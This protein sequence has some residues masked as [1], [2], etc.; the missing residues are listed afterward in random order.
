MESASCVVRESGGTESSAEKS[1]T[2]G[3]RGEEKRNNKRTPSVQ[4]C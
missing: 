4:M 2:S 1:V 3:V